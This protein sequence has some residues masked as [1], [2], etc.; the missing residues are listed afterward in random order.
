MENDFQW[1]LASDFSYHRAS[2]NVKYFFPAWFSDHGLPVKNDQQW[3]TFQMIY[4]MT[5][6]RRIYFVYL[7]VMTL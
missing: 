7:L 4:N 3:K 2:E 5:M 6:F 1:F